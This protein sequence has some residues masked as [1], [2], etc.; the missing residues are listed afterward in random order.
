MSRFFLSF[1]SLSFFSLPP[2]RFFWA[3]ETLT[4]QL[5]SCL[6]K[7]SCVSCCLL[8]QPLRIRF[9]TISPW[10][11]DQFLMLFNRC[12]MDSLDSQHILEPFCLDFRPFLDFFSIFIPQNYSLFL[13]LGNSTMMRKWD[14]DKLS[15]SFGVF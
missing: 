12:Y 9:S 13:K 2:K 8:V 6:F 15:Q 14:S 7:I 10:E 3:S 1:R 11:Y 5:K 4:L